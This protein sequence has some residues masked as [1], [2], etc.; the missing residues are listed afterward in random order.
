M[1]NINM[2]RINSKLEELFSGK[3]DVLDHPDELPIFYSRALAALAIMMECGNGGLK[4]L[5]PFRK[6]NL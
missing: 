2:I 5:A 1:P 3:I 6:M 4:E